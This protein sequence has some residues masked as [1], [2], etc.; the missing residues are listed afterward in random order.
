M[1]ENKENTSNTENVPQHTPMERVYMALELVAARLRELTD[2]VEELTYQNKRVA[3]R[4]QALT[5]HLQDTAEE[6][7]N[8]P[9][10][11]GR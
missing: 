4:L 9:R 2:E 11:I 8:L 10:F 6:E 3:D 1:T 7:S 5:D